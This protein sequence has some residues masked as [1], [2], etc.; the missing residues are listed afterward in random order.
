M[1]RVY[2]EFYDIEVLDRIDDLGVEVH[3]SDTAVGEHDYL[4]TLR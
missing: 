2:G 3:S 1:R 4:L